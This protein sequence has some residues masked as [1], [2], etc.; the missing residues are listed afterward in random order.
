MNAQLKITKNACYLNVQVEQPDPEIFRF[1]RSNSHQERNKNKKLG[2]W[3]FA[4]LRQIIEYKA[5]TIAK[6]VVAI[7][8]APVPDVGSR[9]RKTAMVGPSSAKAAASRSTRI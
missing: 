3:S 4:E 6:N 2:K 8:L 5:A 9:R 1:G 7:L